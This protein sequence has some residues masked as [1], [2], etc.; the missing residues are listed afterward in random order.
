M[1][2]NTQVILWGTDDAEKGVLANPVFTTITDGVDTAQVS[3]VAGGALQVDIVNSIT[4]T[5]TGTVTAN[6]GTPNTVANAW[7]ILVTDGTGTAQVS[8]VSGLG[9]LRVDVVNA[10]HTYG[11]AFPVRGFAVGFYD[12]VNMQSGR[13]YDLNGTGATEYVVGV[14]LR[15]TNPAGG[16]FE[17]GT[18]TNPVRV[19]PTG[20]T[21]QPVSG[22]VT[23]NQG[24]P[25]T[26]ANRWPVLIGGLTPAGG[27]PNAVTVTD[28]GVGLSKALD[29]NIVNSITVGSLFGAAFPATGLAA[30]F[31]NPVTGFMEA[32]T[33]T[34]GP[35][36]TIPAGRQAVDVNVL[37]FTGTTDETRPAS[38]THAIFTVA[39]VGTTPTTFL[40]ANPARRGATF[41]NRT[42][43]RD[44]YLKFFTG[45]AFVPDVSDTNFTVRLSPGGF[46]EIPFPCFNGYVRGLFSSGTPGGDLQV[47]EL[48]P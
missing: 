7:P 37:S 44:C 8:I 11:A 39:V 1:N 14:V 25:N 21:T 36:G 48:T 5:V 13:V 23:A 35:S 10:P 45:P 47:T 26:L 27:G 28:F 33:V 30:G 2:W 24:T 9:A 3:A 29:V 34:V 42:T 38:A 6:Q 4:I 15:Q 20:T 16:S 22:T 40:T 12:G 18:A 31:K 17:I 43:S 46:Y 41:F 32:G 19:D